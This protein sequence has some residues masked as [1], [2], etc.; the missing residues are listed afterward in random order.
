M[1]RNKGKK[2]FN[3]LVT[4]KISKLVKF[5]PAIAIEEAEDYLIDYPYDVLAHH[6]IASALINLGRFYD[7]EDVIK[8]ARII[9]NK[10]I[11]DQKRRIFV[12]EMFLDLEVRLDIIFEDYKKAIE[13][14]KKFRKTYD[15]EQNPNNSCF[16]NRIEDYLYFKLGKS[17]NKETYF[18]S[19]LSNYSYD[20]FLE[21]TKNNAFIKESITSKDTFLEGI[22]I[23]KIF[24]SINRFIPFIRKYYSDVTTDTCYFKIDNIGSG[25]KKTIYDYVEIYLIHGTNNILLAKP[26]PD[27]GEHD[28]LDL[29]YINHYEENNANVKIKRLSQIEK[30]NNKYNN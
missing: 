18:Y 10:K 13:H 21:I 25:S 20:R 24:T 30:F 8:E 9:M 26:I 19:Q 6:S 17:S 14:Y 4:D 15:E 7:A 29:S 1:N 5:Y 22:D 16:L 28:F 2:Y 12:E 11:K 3:S 23:D 27:V